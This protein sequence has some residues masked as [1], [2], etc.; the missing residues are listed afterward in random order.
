MSVI[1]RQHSDVLAELFFSASNME[2]SQRPI[3][4]ISLRDWENRKDVIRGEIVL[5][6]ENVGFFVVVDQESPSPQ[7]IEAMF[8]LS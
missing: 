8:Q 5:A 7:E 3:P 4:R 1:Y 6:A 2:K